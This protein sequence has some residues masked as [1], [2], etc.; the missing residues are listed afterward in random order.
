[1]KILSLHC[2]YI[3]FKALKKAV[4]SA[5]ELGEDEKKEK[6]VKEPLVIF[7]AVEKTDEADGEKAV[8]ELVST[9]LDL[10]EKVN[11]PRVVLYPYA[12]LSSNL[13]SLDFANK[14]MKDAEKKLTGKKIETFRAPF[15]YYKQFEL[16]CKGHPLSE[17]SREIKIGENNIINSEKTFLNLKE[18]KHDETEALKSESKLKSY[19]NIMTAD[20]KLHE[21]D[22]FNFKGYDN[23]K[24]F[25]FYEKTKSREVVKE[26]AHIKVMRMLELVD[27]EPGSDSGN[28]R[29]YPKGRLV[30]ALIEQ[31][32][33]QKVWN[34]GGMEIESPI[35]YDVKHPTLSKYLQ[36]FPA[37][38]YQ[39]ESDKKTF[40]LR[41][42]ACFGQFL[43]MKDSQ[44]S[45]KHLPIKLYELT[46][47]SFRKEQS[48]EVSGLRRLRAFTMPD[49]HAFCKDMEQAI[50]EFKIRFDL[51]LNVLD[52][53]GLTKDDVEL[54]IRFTKD[55]YE[56]NKKLI[57]GLVKKF[58]KPVLI[59]M[60]DERFFYFTLKYELNFVD[61]VDKAA[62]LSTD[63]IDVENAER[64]GI[65]FID[66][67]DKKKFPLILHCSPSGAVER[68]MYALLEKA[69]M[70]GSHKLPY[71]LSPTQLRI[72]PISDKFNK[73]SINL[74]EELTK[75]NIRVDVDDRNETSKKKIV[76]S[77]KEWVPFTIFVGEKEIREGKFLLRERGKKD[78]ES[79]SKEEIKNKLKLLQKEMPWRPLPLPQFLTK[80]VTFV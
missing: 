53:I 49:V 46:R 24:K 68:V 48:G 30:K 69:E 21:L 19:W 12:H 38:Q 55:F 8:S 29:Y 54:A 67:D 17:L 43:M 73:E 41:F 33:N 70:S 16:K 28:L 27:Y 63:Q 71:W 52:E 65:Q 15:G 26:P 14:V 3:K 64:Y 10:K 78:L 75:E 59:E 56:K 37:R 61:S 2:D 11:A 62:A 32:V 7:I 50:E 76:D 22:K 4:K 34:Y 80:Q 40:F 66:R 1:M 60:W 45:Y 72:L 79:L 57:E 23:L 36:R 25:S 44:I 31:Y 39:I 77:E 47:Y 58:G 74:A 42:A 9:I 18:E 6:E 5:E 13:S 20:G 51:C 35:M